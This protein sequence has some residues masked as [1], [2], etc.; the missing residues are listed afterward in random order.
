M[1]PVDPYSLKRLVLLLLEPEI[2]WFFY[3]CFQMQLVRYV[4]V[5]QGALQA[6]IGDYADGVSTLMRALAA[7][8]GGLYKLNP[9]QVESSAP[10]AWR[11]RLISTLD[12]EI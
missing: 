11:K 10:I 2:S 5:A 9:V 8:V 6:D 7:T 3:P 1:N 12:I 4:M